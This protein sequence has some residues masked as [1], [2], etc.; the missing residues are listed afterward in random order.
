RWGYNGPY[1]GIF[2]QGLY[3][4]DRPHVFK[5]T[6]VYQLPFGK[7]RWIASNAHGLLNALIG[8]WEWTTFLTA[9][10]GEPAD[11]PSNVRILRDPKLTPNWHSAKVQGWRPCVLRMDDSGVITPMPYSLLAGCGSDQS[12]YNFMILPNYAPRETPLRS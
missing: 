5:L 9:Q 6:T 11:L 2:Q 8:D 1:R 3:N 12:T 10:S 7:G 4:S